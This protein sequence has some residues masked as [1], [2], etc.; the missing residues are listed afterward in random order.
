MLSI[1]IPTLNAAEF[2]EARMNSILNQT[3]TDWELIICDSYSED[4]TW[5]YFSRFKGD[6]RVRMYRVPKEGLYAGWNECLRR[7]RGNYVHIATAD[8]FEE[9]VF[10]AEL[11]ER[12]MDAP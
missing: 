9:P 12:L 3:Y 4:G 11:I 1:L 8:D 7:A 5:E 2:L 6:P 10:Y